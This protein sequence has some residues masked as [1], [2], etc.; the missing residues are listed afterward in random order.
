MKAKIPQAGD[1]FFQSLGEGEET[2]VVSITRP[3]VAHMMQCDVIQAGWLITQVDI[4]NRTLH[5][6]KKPNGTRD[7]PASSCCNLKENYPYLTTGM[8]PLVGWGGDSV[9]ICVT[10]SILD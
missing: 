3:L 1:K 9:T 8:S 6:H 4:L 5:L 10:R 2:A 7:F